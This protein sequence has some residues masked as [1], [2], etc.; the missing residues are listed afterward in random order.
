ML[1]ELAGEELIPDEAFQVKKDVV[2]F[3]FL[4]NGKAYEGSDDCS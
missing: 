3:V 4:R 2:I 1:L